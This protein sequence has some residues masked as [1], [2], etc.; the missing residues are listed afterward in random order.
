MNKKREMN[1][2]I[3]GAYRGVEGRRKEEK[4]EPRK[5]ENIR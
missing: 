2:T 5:E 1:K 3:E 4:K